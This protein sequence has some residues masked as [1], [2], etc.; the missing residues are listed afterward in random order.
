MLIQLNV[1]VVN[2]LRSF[3]TN[4]S[5]I[6]GHVLDFSALDAAIALGFGFPSVAAMFPYLPTVRMFDNRAFDAA[7][8]EA[9]EPVLEAAAGRMLLFKSA[10]IA[11]PEAL[12]AETESEEEMLIVA[13]LQF[14]GWVLTQ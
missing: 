11:V 7:I 3:F 2:T 6:L 12:I 4:S 8:M 13:R 14:T 5:P 1:A 9:A 10:V